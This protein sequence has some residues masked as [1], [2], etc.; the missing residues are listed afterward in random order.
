[1]QGRKRLLVS[2]QRFYQ[3]LEH[4]SVW[5]IAFILRLSFT[6]TAIDAPSVQCRFYKAL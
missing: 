5:A 6:P 3:S 1:M 2:G 4:W